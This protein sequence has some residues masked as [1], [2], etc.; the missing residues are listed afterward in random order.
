MKRMK[1]SYEFKMAHLN[2]M[3]PIDVTAAR[4]TS[5]FTS[6]TWNMRN[7][8]FDSIVSS[9]AHEYWI[10]IVS[11]C[12]GLKWRE[13][14]MHAIESLSDYSYCSI[15]SISSIFIGK[16]L[17]ILYTSVQRWKLCI[18]F[19][20]ALWYLRQCAKAFWSLCCCQFHSMPWPTCTCLSVSTRGP[21]LLSS[22]LPRDR[23]LPNARTW[24]MQY[25]Q[26]N[27][28]ISSHAASLG[29]TEN[30]G[31]IQWKIFKQLLLLLMLLLN[32]NF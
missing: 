17:K 31:T 16:L 8:Y 2:K 1:L 14:K 6:D 26:L 20:D 32:N 5:S 4:R 22:W 7:R 27:R 9:Q 18:F 24:W 25:R 29:H 12:F 15:S 13:N 11:I 30:D 3:K 21:Y 28:A 10:V 19:I 23:L